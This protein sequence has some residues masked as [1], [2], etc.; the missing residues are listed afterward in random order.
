[1]G[2]LNA[3]AVPDGQRGN[4]KVMEIIFLNDDIDSDM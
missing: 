2:R 4:K 1:V 3:V